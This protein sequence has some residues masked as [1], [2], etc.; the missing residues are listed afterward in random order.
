MEPGGHVWDAIACG[1]G[2]AVR[3]LNKADARG[4]K[5][6]CKYTT[7]G[8]LF[9]RAEME[10]TVRIPSGEPNTGKRGSA[11]KRGGATPTA[12]QKRGP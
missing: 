7:S 10:E 12:P 9:R 8:T 1:G 2:S 3:F 6:T 11:C 4:A 5:K